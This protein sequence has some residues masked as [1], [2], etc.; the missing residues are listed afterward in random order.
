MSK[1][2][3]MRPRPPAARR[4]GPAEQE[5]RPC[6]SP[7]GLDSLIELLAKKTVATI[8][9]REAAARRKSAQSD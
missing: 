6:F 9:A 5:F 2:T 7:E 8:R 3:R 1:V 4:H